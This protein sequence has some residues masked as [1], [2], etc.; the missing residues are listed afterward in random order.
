MT[1]SRAVFPLSHGMASTSA[2]SS[3]ITASYCSILFLRTSLIFCA[4]ERFGSSRSSAE[5]GF[6]G[7]ANDGIFEAVRPP[8]DDQ[9][10]PPPQVC[11]LHHQPLRI[12]TEAEPEHGADDVKHEEAEQDL[13]DALEGLEAEEG[14]PLLRV[15][16]W[17][18]LVTVLG[19]LLC[20]QTEQLRTTEGTGS[21]PETEARPRPSSSTGIRR[22]GVL[23][24]YWQ[25][26]LSS[27]LQIELVGHE[28]E[29]AHERQEAPWNYNH[30]V[31]PA[32]HDDMMLKWV[33][34]PPR[35]D[36][37]R[38]RW[39]NWTSWRQGLLQG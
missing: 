32:V 21:L 7:R 29:D 2:R 27:C 36:L 17:V 38:G 10:G 22:R 34:H 8:F 23:R 19:P 30:H 1:N 11:D 18:A 14:R 12:P 33:D 28:A 35:T 3:P 5:E 37:R 39:P 31:F 6:D 26:E 9:R 15:V 24:T 4:R 16:S 20:R 25:I 13:D